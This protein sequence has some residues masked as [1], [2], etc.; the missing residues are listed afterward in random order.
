MS[1]HHHEDFGRTMHGKGPSDRNFGWV[2]TAAFLTFG[3]WPRLH[4]RPVRPGWLAAAAVLLAI[5][6]VRPSLLHLPNLAW[7]RLGLLLGKVM[8]PLVTGLLFFVVFTPAALVLRLRGKDLLKL[9]R[10]PEAESYWERR[11]P[12]DETASMIN[13]F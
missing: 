8:N 9:A 4:G 11:T 10:E 1:T 13:Q 3:L 5:S 6:L 12:S 7:T 2:F